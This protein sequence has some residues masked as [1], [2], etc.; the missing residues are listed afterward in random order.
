MSKVHYTKAKVKRYVG[1]LHDLRRKIGRLTP[2]I[3]VN[4]ARSPTSPLHD[5]FE[6][7][8]TAAAEKWRLHQAREIVCKLQINIGTEDNPKMVRTM[9]C[10]FG[11][12]DKRS[13]QPIEAIR[14]DARLSAEVMA[15]AKSDMECWIERYGIYH[16]LL[17]AKT[18]A[19]KA[20]AAIKR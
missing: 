19:L 15:R 12:D 16:E 4:G 3:I 1:Y 10:L 2:E 20:L 5:L 7:D 18:L 14:A 11:E 9:F 8:N 17:E 6:W 13:Y